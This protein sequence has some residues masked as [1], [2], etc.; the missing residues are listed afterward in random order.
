MDKSSWG[1]AKTKTPM[2]TINRGIYK[3]VTGTRRESNYCLG[4][5]KRG[6]L[7]SVFNNE[8][9]ATKRAE[10]KQYQKQYT[11]R[12]GTMKEHKKLEA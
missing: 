12:Y 2:N 11:Q 8:I 1:K 4:D 5:C 10:R 6:Q 9:L 7:T 3:S